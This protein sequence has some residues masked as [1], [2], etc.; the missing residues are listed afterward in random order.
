MA[1]NTLIQKIK[2]MNK[3]YAKLNDE[4]VSLTILINEN[5]MYRDFESYFKINDIYYKLEKNHFYLDDANDNEIILNDFGV[6]F[7]FRTIGLY[8]SFNICLEEFTPIGNMF[9]LEKQYESLDDNSN[10]MQRKI[11]STPNEDLERI[12]IEYKDR[13]ELLKNNI[14][15]IKKN[16]SIDTYKYYYEIYDGAVK[17]HNDKFYSIKEL[18]DKIKESYP[19]F[20]L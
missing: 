18:L 8:Y 7:A 10:F 3:D 11:F 2:E 15:F 5:I 1:S 13:I 6:Q 16:A 12:I 4:Y 19:K 14:E 17:V 9:L 20:Y